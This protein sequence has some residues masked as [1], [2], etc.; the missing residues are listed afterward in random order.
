[1]FA[2]HRPSTPSQRQIQSSTIINIFQWFFD[3]IFANVLAPWDANVGSGPLA[4]APASPLA[5]RTAKPISRRSQKLVAAELVAGACAAVQ[6]P[7][8]KIANS[9]ITS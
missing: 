3:S 6:Q 9:E 2:T 4:R 1:M 7:I 5:A 8:A